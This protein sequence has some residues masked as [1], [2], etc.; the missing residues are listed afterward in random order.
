LKIIFKNEKLFITKKK[1][2]K[3]KMFDPESLPGYDVNN[4]GKLPTYDEYIESE[5]REERE[6][7]E[8]QKYN[9]L[10]NCLTILLIILMYFFIKNIFK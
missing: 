4:P 2:P 6:D 10:M 1:Y 8:D 7:K 5:E 3:L 9:T